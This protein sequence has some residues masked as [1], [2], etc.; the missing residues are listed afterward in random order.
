[1]NSDGPYT[2]DEKFVIKAFGSLDNITQNM[3]LAWATLARIE[4][5]AKRAQNWISEAMG[6]NFGDK[7]THIIPS[8]KPA[9]SETL[10][11]AEI[12]LLAGTATDEW[13]TQK[14]T[15][16]ESVDAVDVTESKEKGLGYIYAVEFGDYIKIGYTV[17]PKSRLATHAATARNYGTFKTGRV[18]LSPPHK[19]YIKTEKTLHDYFTSYRKGGTELFELDFKDM[20]AQIRA[21]ITEVSEQG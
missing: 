4:V 2:A 13:K 5:D 16:Y 17:S 18:L 19:D 20:E 12:A 11:E 8:E 6:L 15:T 3:F 10:S 21:A 1:M 9:E 7:S 14:W